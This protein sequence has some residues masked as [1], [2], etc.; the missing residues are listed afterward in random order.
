M[1]IREERKRHSR[2]ALLVIMVAGILG[3][4]VGTFLGAV[5]PDGSFHDLVSKSLAFGFDP[6]CRL[7]FWIVSFSVGFTLELNSCSFLFM[8]FALLFYKRV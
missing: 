2:I 4:L 7:D 1:L 3:N 6:P 8:F 5:L